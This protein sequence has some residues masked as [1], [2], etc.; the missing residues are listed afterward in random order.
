[1]HRWLRLAGDD[2]DAVI[3]SQRLSSV[4]FDEEDHSNARIQPILPLL[5][6]GGQTLATSLLKCL[7]KYWKV[8]CLLWRHV[9]MFIKSD[10]RIRIV[11]L[12]KLFNSIFLL[13]AIW[14]FWPPILVWF[15]NMYTE[16]EEGPCLQQAACTARGVCKISPTTSSYYCKCPAGLHGDFCQE[17]M[18]M[19]L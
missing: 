7:S 17:G 14:Y 16:K 10:A 18:N 3:N 5:L 2:T 15:C 11:Y 13:E 9:H 4:L 8:E 1:M 12:F 19:T 6:T